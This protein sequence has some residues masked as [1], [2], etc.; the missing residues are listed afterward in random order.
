MNQKPM[1]PPTKKK[2]KENDHHI[3]MK[4]K[5]NHTSSDGQGTRCVTK[6]REEKTNI[7]TKNPKK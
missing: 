4:R 1:N 5:T 2:V 3:S 6:R 7:E